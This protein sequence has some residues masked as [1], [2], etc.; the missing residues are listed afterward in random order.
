V[1]E[2]TK[3]HYRRLRAN[4]RYSDCFVR[5]FPE[6]NMSWQKASRSAEF[7]SEVL[8]DNGCEAV[9][10]FSK[11]GERIGILTTDERKIQYANELRRSMSNMRIASESDWIG[12]VG[13]RASILKELR[14]QMGNFR[15]EIITTGEA[16]GRQRS[17][18]NVSGKGAGKKDDI[19]MALC[20]ALLYMVEAQRDL[21]FVNRM[22][23]LGK[24]TF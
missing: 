9:R 13:E 2:T 22:Q 19:V 6:G 11:E 12:K 1:D 17:H 8:G 5:L 24:A 10:Y 20:I 16:S 23:R 15:E 7:A 18:H 14:K 4:P 21:P 3:G